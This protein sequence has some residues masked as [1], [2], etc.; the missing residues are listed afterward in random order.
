[1]VFDEV[2]IWLWP[3]FNSARLSPNPRRTYKI[4]SLPATTH[5]TTIPY[6]LLKICTKLAVQYSFDVSQHERQ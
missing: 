3:S 2:V 4:S 1:M 5:S 6:Y